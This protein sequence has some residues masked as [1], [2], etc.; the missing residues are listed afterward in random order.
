MQGK[1]S[2]LVG[3]K[4]GKLTV[5]E[6]TS[7]RL[8]GHV[9]WRCRCDCGNVKDTI[10]FRL[11]N[12]DAR[13]CGCLQSEKVITHGMTNSPEYKAWD[14]I[15]NRC[16]NPNDP[17]Y[18]D[19]G[20]RGIALDEKWRTFEKFYEDVGPRPSINY[21]LDRKDND[22]GYVP[23]NVRWATAVEQ[24]NNRRNNVVVQ[25]NG[26][27]L[28]LAQLSRKTGISYN[29]VRDRF[30]NGISLEDLIKE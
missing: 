13:S 7:K 21:S 24:A 8:C 1:V 16:N 5:I 18:S 2:E 10:G 25:H 17:R 22:K 20:G 29:T 14:N 23:G 3:F 26:E 27:T 15:K 28:T 11:K 30:K 4:F 19:Y 12:G 9:V 6:K